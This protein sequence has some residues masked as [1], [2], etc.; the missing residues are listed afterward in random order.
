MISNVVNNQSSFIGSQIDHFQHLCYLGKGSFGIVAKMKSLFNNQIYAV[1]YVDIPKGDNMME[2]NIKIMREAI[3]MGNINHPNIVRLYTAFQDNKFQY[4]VSEF[5]QGQNLE[6]FV[7]KHKQQGQHLKQ[8]LVISIFKQIL[9]G[10]IYLH[11]NG[12]MH[13]D[14]K[15]DN[16]LIDAYNNIKITDFGISALYIKHYGILS[17][18]GTRV[19]RRDYVCPEILLNKPYDFKCDI[20]S[21]GYT[22][23]FI[24]NYDLP[25]ITDSDG[26][27][28]QKNNLNFNNNYDRNLVQLIERMYRDN[29]A[30]RPTA[31]EALSKLLIIENNIN[32]N[33]N[34]S[35]NVQSDNSLFIS[36]LNCVLQCLFGFNNI[37]MLKN[38]VINNLKSKQI[39][40]LFFPLEFFNF[41]DLIEKKRNNSIN[42]FDYNKSLQILLNHL[43]Q[44]NPL[45]NSAKPKDLYCNIL[46][47]FQ[48]EFNLLIRWTNKMIT[49]KYKN[50]EHYPQNI[51]PKVVNEIDN[52]KKNY[53]NPLADMFYFI[54]ITSRRCPNCK[55]VY[56]ANSEAKSFLPL[57][58]QN[59]GNI[60]TLI[61]YYFGQKISNQFIQCRCG[62]NKNLVEEIEFYNTPDYLVL[63]LV[64]NGQIEVDEEIDLSEYIKTNYGSRQFKLYAVIN[65][66]VVNNS[67]VQYVCSIKEKDSYTFYEGDS[68]DKSGNECLKIGFPS[69]VIYK[70]ITLKT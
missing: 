47:L 56:Y 69:C 35:L 4:F 33:F 7:S 39:N 9:N 48:K 18:R 21:L 16:I 37:G 19:G 43:K 36:S 41:F 58:N 23:Y 13:R 52:F 54:L 6:Q 2:E 51:F 66:K 61:R 14:I 55:T 53:N 70:K 40:F 25:S 50:P 34:R 22:M 60:M 27:R 67:H 64:E 26:N 62:Y 29:P 42:S 32:N 11:S 5:I 46:L 1:K 49:F 31:N 44:K 28:M 30:E 17:S 12:I 59:K 57:N 68:I 3:I 38:I 8:N 15:P 63:D 45:I 65:K 24:M 10:L 20:F